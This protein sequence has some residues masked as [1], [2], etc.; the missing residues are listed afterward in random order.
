[1]AS[2]HRIGI[3]IPAVCE[4]A[5]VAKFDLERKGSGLD[6]GIRAFT[7]DG[8]DSL[9]IVLVRDI[10]KEFKSDLTCTHIIPADCTQVCY[11]VEDPCWRIGA[12]GRLEDRALGAIQPERGCTHYC[13]V[14]SVAVRGVNRVVVLVIAESFVVDVVAEL[15]VEG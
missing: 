3:P 13:L 14:Y 4:V 12:V 5:V 15:D 11:R 6:F 1:V 7:H 8:I 10:Q 2:V 9:D